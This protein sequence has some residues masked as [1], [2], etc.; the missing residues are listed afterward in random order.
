METPH[1]DPVDPT[2]PQAAPPETV[3]A[4]A[5]HRGPVPTSAVCGA[6][7]RQPAVTRCSSCGKQLCALCTFELGGWDF[8]GDC[9]LRQ[10]DVA[11]GRRLCP[12]C[13]RSMPAEAETCD[14]GRALEKPVS[15]SPPAR[16]WKV[17]EG[18]CVNHLGSPAVITCALC[19]RSICDV[20]DFVLPGGIHVCPSCIEAQSTADASPKRKSWSYL[21]LGLAAWST[22]LFALLVG[23]LFN[24]I[25]NSEGG[26]EASGVIGAAILWPCVIGTGIAVAARDKRLKNTGLMNAAV[27]W[28]AIIAGI[29]LL[30]I[31]ANNLGL[32]GE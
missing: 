8:C 27:W 25:F 29:F 19:A 32:T 5:A 28:N 6:H 17:P 23:G 12:E 21:A 10:A 9:A 3:P 16:R 18:A 20:C 4:S 7:P 30:L 13:G 22:L 14:C 31:L 2:L 26:E 15:A 11:E 1:G 24:S